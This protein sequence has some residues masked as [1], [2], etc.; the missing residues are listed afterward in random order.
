[1]LHCD[2]V[3]N[4]PRPRGVGRRTGIYGLIL[5]AL[6]ASCRSLP[7]HALGAERGEPTMSERN[8]VAV[9]P[10]EVQ[11]IRDCGYA[12][13]ASAEVAA[14]IRDKFAAGRIPVKG[15]RHVRIWGI[16]VD[17]E[18]ELPGHERTQIPDEDLWQVELEAL[19]GS[20]FEVNSQ[21]LVAA[22]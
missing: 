12:T 16:Q 8:A 11:A 20:H 15:V 17:D 4:A 9:M 14:A 18:R 2:I 22:P 1:M 13:W 21:L 3:E 10:P 19:D 7:V 6:A 5:R